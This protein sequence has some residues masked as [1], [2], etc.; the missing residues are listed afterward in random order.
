MSEAATLH[1]EAGALE[2]FVRAIVAGTGSTRQ[3]AEEV[4][5][6]LLEANLQGHDSHGIMLLPRYVQH[7]RE[8]KLTPNAAPDPVRQDPSLAL[9]DGR[10]GY[11]QHVGRIAMDWA[12]EAAR[13][14]GHAVMGLRNVHHIG[15]VGTYGEQAARA[16]MISVHFVNGVSGPPAVAPFGGSAARLSTNPVCITIPPAHPNG[17]PLVLDFA[18]SAIALGK[19]RV[20]FNAGRAVPDGALVD[21]DGQPTNDPGVLYRGE[22]RGAL[23]SFGAH[24]GY[25]LALVC[26]LL[27]GA[28]LGGA[29]AWRPEMRDRGIVNSWLAFVLDPARFGDVEAFRAELAA[30]IED[31]KSSPAA[32][33][34]S[35]V[36]VAGEKERITKARRLATGVPVDANTWAML[37][38]AARSLGINE[39]PEAR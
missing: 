23:L 18:T 35:P 12:I 1:V 15:R 37:V 25:G 9:F 29:T 4:A 21:A 16:G 36:L 24:K 10:M 14:H 31:V 22:P 13:R 2:G 38:D 30:V 26:E 34:D 5:A 7:V 27:A 11:G 39:V 32:D 28:L 19:C 3:E 17:Q 33:P 6:H 20:A 8:G